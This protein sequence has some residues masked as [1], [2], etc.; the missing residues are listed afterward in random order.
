[1]VDRDHPLPP[2]TDTYKQI[3][4]GPPTIERN[5]ED[6]T[7][8][9]NPNPNDCTLE[10]SDRDCTLEVDRRIQDSNKERASQTTT[11]GQTTSGQTEADESG[12]GQ[13]ATATTQARRRKRIWVI[14]FAVVFSVIVLLIVII[15]P[16]VTLKY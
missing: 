15:I 9:V 14:T 7:L 2:D 4:P 5:G 3:A 8:Q 6:C 1:M 16:T 11:G 12:Q 10:P 13:L